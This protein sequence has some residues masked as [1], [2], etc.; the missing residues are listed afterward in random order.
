MRAEARTRESSN[1]R[2]P[3]YIKKQVKKMKDYKVKLGAMLAFD[4]K[5][6]KDLIEFVQRLTERKLLGEFISNTIRLVYEN[7]E[8]AKKLGYDLEK[9][10]LKD[11][12]EEFFDGIQKQVKEMGDKIDKI[13]DMAFKLFVM[14]EFGTVAGIKQQSENLAGAQLVLQNQ[15]REL[16]DTLGVQENRLYKSNEFVGMGKK[17][18]EAMAYITSHYSNEVTTILDSFGLIQGRLMGL[19]GAMQ[20]QPMMMP[21]P[22]G[23]DMMNTAGFASM[24]QA[25]AEAQKNNVNANQ[26]SGEQ[27][28]TS[29]ESVEKENTADERVINTEEYKEELEKHSEME[30]VGA[31]DDT[32]SVMKFDDSEDL[33][34][35][36]SF[37]GF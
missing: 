23:T 8:E 3:K 2:K 27:T 35:L 36:E 10:R 1:K 7:Q 19:L 33:S 12:R 21:M 9:F 14:S 24:M 31:V 15:L 34:M 26:G 16:C 5:R 13:Y 32:D 4:S 37:F 28:G 25:Y 22:M 17:A 6:E 11:D 30:E 20:M 29:G 18:E